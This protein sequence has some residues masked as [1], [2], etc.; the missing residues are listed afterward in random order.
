MFKKLFSICSL[1]LFAASSQRS[2][3]AQV[4]MQD[5]IVESTPLRLQDEVIYAPHSIA[6]EQPASDVYLGETLSK[7]PGILVRN[8]SGF[9]STTTV[10]TSQA[11][12]SAGTAV[13]IDDIP[14]VESSGRGVNFSLFPSALISA[15][16]L[17]SPFYP[18]LDP[19]S[20]ALPSPGGRIN[21]QTLRRP[22]PDET[23]WVG[24]LIL[25]SGKTVSGTMGYR[26]GNKKRDWVAG[27]TGYNTVGD[28]HYHDPATDQAANR[29]NN[30]A[31]GMGAL[32]KHRWQLDSGGSVE[33]LDLFSSSDRTNPGS[34]YLPTRQH[35]KDMFNLLGARF[36]DPKLLGAHDGAFA[37]AAI[38]YARTATRGPGT[39]ESDPGATT[40]SRSY[41]VYSQAGYVR[42][43]ELSIFTL[44]IDD[45]YD[46]L[47]KDEGVFNRNVFGTTAT[48]S[49]GRG[50]FR[51]VPLLRYDAS[52]RFVSAG[53][54]SLSVIYSANESTELSLSYGLQHTYPSITAVSGFANSGLFVL[55][56]SDL[57]VQRDNIV[58]LSYDRRSRLYALHSSAF[59]DLIRNR[60]TF[61]FIDMTTAKFVNSTEVSAWGYTLDGQL[62]PTDEVSLRASLTLQRAWDRAT[63]HEMP[64]KPRL[65]GW[66]AASYLFTPWLGLT[67]QEQFIGKRFIST[68]GVDAVSP[69]AQT[70][71]R[72]DA[73]FGP[74]VAYFKVTNL[75]D[76]G[77]FENPGFPFPGRAYW[78]GYSVGAQPL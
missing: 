55:P 48:L 3:H 59:Y 49:L 61:T 27:L 28:Y 63:G 24:S 22:G 71:A 65:E 41:G 18:A 36:S 20:N 5:V 44:S 19:E 39:G 1:V 72:V 57:R 60:S 43:E 46:D 73:R 35:Q 15:V 68:N 10:I 77:A 34:I 40:D 42:K 76:A 54:A 62:F 16:E 21:L 30:D 8:T 78:L 69:F 23:P 38:A 56:N 64:Y 13:S 66:G 45:Q 67:L 14:V 17:H 29:M 31:A 70:I 26:G 58:S 52:S 6:I 75:L 51:A 33:V 50:A 37:K 7:L 9:G 4:R 25:G 53:D 2:A 74:G 47:R 11:L 12:G 32:A